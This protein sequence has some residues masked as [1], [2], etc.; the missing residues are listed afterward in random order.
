M[1]RSCKLIACLTTALIANMAADPR[2][3]DTGPVDQTLLTRQQFEHASGEQVYRH[4]CQACHMLDGSGATGAASYPALAGNPNVASAQYMATIVLHG[5]GNMPSF[6]TRKDLY[7][8]Q[9]QTHVNLGD[10]E[11]AAVVNFVRSHF[12]NHYADQLTAADVTAL[13]VSSLELE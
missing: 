1:I 3:A 12:G 2:Y 11:I 9:A 13:R 6:E 5:R 10:A 7:G 8:F 4:I